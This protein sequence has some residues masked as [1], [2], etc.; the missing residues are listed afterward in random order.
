MFYPIFLVVSLTKVTVAVGYH[1][2]DDNDDDDDDGNYDDRDD[3]DNNVGEEEQEE[4]GE[5]VDKTK[6]SRLFKEN[7]K[8]TRSQ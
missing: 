2:D 8:N 7:E 1:D 3:G 6:R 4:E 5:E